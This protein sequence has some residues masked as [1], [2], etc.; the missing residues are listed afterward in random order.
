M[1]QMITAD[2]G[3]KPPSTSMSVNGNTSISTIWEIAEP[4]E[5]D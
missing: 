4:R 3:M 5:I 1:A 2:P